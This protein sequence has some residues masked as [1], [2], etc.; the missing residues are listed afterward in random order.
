MTAKPSEKLQTKAPESAGIILFNADAPNTIYFPHEIKGVTY[1]VGHT[2][3]PLADSRYFQYV[4]EIEQA[5]KRIAQKETLE[6]KS[7]DPQAHL[8][9]DLVSGRVGYA[10]EKADWKDRVHVFTK[11]NVVK[12]FLSS[13]IVEDEKEQAAEGELPDDSEETLEVHLN[14]VQNG[15][16]IG[17]RH[18]FREESV[19]DLDE[20]FAI[21]SN[22]PQKNV[23][24]SAKKKTKV[25]RLCEL[26][27]SVCVEQK[28]YEGRVPA[29]HKVVV[30]EH[31]FE[32]RTVLLGKSEV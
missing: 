28:Y 11:T 2:F 6:A 25:E 30:V 5:A 9:N 15:A 14:A 27:D 8:W 10:N 32:H 7:F 24:A 19:D 17:T 18:I 12:L 16:L 13:T 21:K 3:E 31:F 20:Y 26:Y 1:R 22:A 23:L 29:W 4:S